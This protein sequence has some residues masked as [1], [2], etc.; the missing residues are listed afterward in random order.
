MVDRQSLGNAG[1]RRSRTASPTATTAAAQAEPRAAPHQGQPAADQHRGVHADQLSR[2]TA[3]RTLEPPG[4]WA[5]AQDHSAISFDFRS[6][7]L[8]PLPNEGL[9]ASA[10]QG[11][12]TRVRSVYE[13]GTCHS[14]LLQPKISYCASPS[15]SLHRLVESGQLSH[16]RPRHHSLITIV[17][18]SSYANLSLSLPAVQP[19][20]DFCCI[21]MQR[22]ALHMHERPTAGASTCLAGRCAV[23]IMS[24]NSKRKKACGCVSSMSSQAFMQLAPT[25][26]CTCIMT[27]HAMGS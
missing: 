22:S 25:T 13:F 10:V 7:S 2:C 11:G 3:R 15:T 26:F 27:M 5:T 4:M 23:V 16:P 8:C 12:A 17:S 24:L 1:W 18:L 19:R 21:A 14:Q 9:C 6:T 20:S